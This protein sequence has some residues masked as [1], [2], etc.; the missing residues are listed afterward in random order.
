MMGLILGGLLAYLIGA[1]PMGY[2]LTRVTKKIDI[3]QHGSG[4][5]GATNVLRTAGKTA[6]VITLIFDI[7]KGYFVVQFLPSLL[8]CQEYVFVLGFIVIAGHNWPVFLKFKGGKGVAT[9]AGVLLAL[10]PKLLL[11]GLAAWILVFAFTKIVSVSSII[12]AAAIPTAALLLQYS[13]NVR[14]FTAAVAILTILR[15]S[16]NIKRLLK[17]EE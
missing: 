1:I 15:H 2:L 6:A 11:I 7:L 3:R 14:I 4:N 9:S 16:E 10:C 13:P 5:I 12:S 17:G 8:Q